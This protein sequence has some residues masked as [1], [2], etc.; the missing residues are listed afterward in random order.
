M[1]NNLQ[2]ILRIEGVRAKGVGMIPKSVMQD[3][4]LTI[5]SKAI[6]AYFCSCAGAG[7]TTFPNVKKICFDLGIKTPDTF[8]KHLQYLKDCDYI[9]VTRE[10]REKGQFLQ[11]HIL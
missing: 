1:K 5:K 7:D 4:R 3:T 2:D 10:R 11:I 8:R 9:R 6:Y